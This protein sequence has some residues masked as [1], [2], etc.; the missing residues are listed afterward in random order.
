VPH[1]IFGPGQLS[2]APN[3]LVIRLQPDEGVRLSVLAKTPG[4]EILLRP[5]DLNLDL[6]QTFGV[7]QMDAYERLLMDA[8]CGK[9]TLFLRRD[10]LDAAWRWIDPILHAWERYGDKPKNYL[11]GT[12][13]PA[14][15]TALLSRD[16]ITWHEES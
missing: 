2:L 1:S 15:S 7:V 11:A 3:R 14:A 8:I 12:W 4:D 5:V 10:E 13:G 16:G 9:L 6:A